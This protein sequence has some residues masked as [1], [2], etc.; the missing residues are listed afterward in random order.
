MGDPQ[1]R[2]C[3]KYAPLF[4]ARLTP[5]KPTTWDQDSFRAP[6]GSVNSLRRGA[7]FK[8][9]E[10]HDGEAEVKVTILRGAAPAF[11]SGHGL[12]ADNRVSQPYHP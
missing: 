7:I 9:M 8:A 2:R 12:S 4:A 6:A 10:A 5:S 1:S 11:C 3:G